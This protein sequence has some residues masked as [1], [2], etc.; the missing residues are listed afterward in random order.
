MTLHQAIFSFLTQLP[1]PA[2]WL[3]LLSLW[4]RF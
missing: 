1:D 4:L 3:F 2:F